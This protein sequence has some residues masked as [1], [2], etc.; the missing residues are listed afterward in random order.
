VRRVERHHDPAVLTRALLAGRH[1]GPCHAAAP[2]VGRNAQHPDVRLPWGER[3]VVD[4]VDT[5]V[6]LQGRR[7]Q[8]LA[9]LDRDQDRRALGSLRHRGQV[10][11]VLLPRRLARMHELAVRLDRYTAGLGVL[12]GTRLPDR[13]RHGPRLAQAARSNRQAG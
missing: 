9:V 4:L 12:V 8:D 13:D 6:E 10:V 2:G 1:Q 11:E 7:A 3:S 5:A